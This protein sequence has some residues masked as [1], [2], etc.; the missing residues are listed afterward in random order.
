MNPHNEETPRR[1]APGGF[2]ISLCIHLHI[3]F[4]ALSDDHR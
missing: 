4:F 3:V 1:I 2:F